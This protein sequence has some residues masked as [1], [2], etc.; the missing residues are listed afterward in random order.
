MDELSA[1][2]ARRLAV[3]AQGLAAPRPRGRLDRRHARGVLERLGAL[4]LDSVSAVARAHELA[5]FARLGP[6]PR[7][8]D[9]RLV[10]A[11]EAFE[12]WGHQASLLPVGLHPLLRWRMERWVGPAWD[13]ATRL[14]RERPG[15]LDALVDRV[16]EHGPVA[17]R[18]LSEGGRRGP[19]WG[20]DD[21]KL[22]LELLFWRGRLAALRRGGFERVYDLP[23]RVVPAAV[24]AAPTPPEDDARRELLMRSAAALGVGTAGDLFD[25]YRLRPERTRHVLAGMVE[26]GRLV[27]VRVQGWGE[28]AYALRGAAPPARVHARARVLAPFDS[29][30]WCR[31]RLERMFGMRYRIEIYTPEARRVHGYYVMPVLVGDRIVG[32]LDVRASRREGVLR[33]LAAWAE[34]RV[35]AGRVAEPV[36]RE[37]ALMA[38]WLTGGRLEVA[39]RGDLAPAL[40]RAAA[41]APV[42]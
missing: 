33:V 21:A 40:R 27:R 29:L 17:A 8:L 36:A 34:P 38:G 13:A 20:W 23:E 9:R 2:E 11:G 1:A 42:A 18:D 41:A 4:Q 25:Y 37:L 19:W 35:P 16:R 6:H 14:E 26:E 5:L 31:P 39:D 15:Y 22:A 3:A 24:L 12:Y 10:A 28:P 30:V 7:D 32:R